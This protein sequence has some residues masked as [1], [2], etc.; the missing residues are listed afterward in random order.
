MGHVRG[1]DQD[2]GR[3]PY[4]LPKADHGEED[5]EKHRRYIGVNDGQR[6]VEGIWNA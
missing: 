6:G 2:V 3:K 5:V 1:Y 4:K